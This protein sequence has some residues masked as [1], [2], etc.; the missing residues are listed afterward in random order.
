MVFN[1]IFGK[2]NSDKR[3]MCYSG[4]FFFIS[5]YLSTLAR[6]YNDI[7]SI[8]CQNYSVIDNYIIFLKKSDIIYD[9]HV[10][11]IDYNFLYVPIFLITFVWIF[12]FS[13][14]ALKIG[15][16]IL[17]IIGIF[18]LYNTISS[19]ST[20]YYQTN[21]YCDYIPE[22]YDLWSL[23]RCYTYKDNFLLFGLIMFYVF[24]RYHSSNFIRITFMIL[25]LFNIY[26]SLVAK[27]LFINQIIDILVISYLMWS[28][29][30][31]PSFFKTLKKNDRKKERKI[32]QKLK[33]QMQKTNLY[34]DEIEINDF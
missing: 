5:L 8:N 25:N 13:N 19:V 23:F 2:S 14:M 12:F 33:I 29:Y 18:L 21:N 10:F 31:I 1:C 6:R 15:K 7:M 28:V 34:K 17:T 26:F 3:Y 22:T 24:N 30:D 11:I 20:I 32:M 27:Q 16:R 4:V 9:I